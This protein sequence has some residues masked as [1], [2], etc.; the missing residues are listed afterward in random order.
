MYGGLKTKTCNVCNTE[1]SVNNHTRH[2]LSCNGT[3]TKKVRGV[4]FDPNWGYKDGSRA[5]WNKGK[6]SKP[7]NRSA[8]FI[9]KVGGYR[10]NAGRS[11]K[12]KVKDSLGND[13]TLQSTYELE[14]S[15]ILNL[16]S[17]RWIRPKALKYDN[18]NYF[19]DFYLLDYDVYLD[20]KN[21]YKAKQ[22]K[23]KIEKVIE[24][25][26]VKVF[27]LLKEQLNNEYILSVIR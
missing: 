15:E 26:G 7:D 17:I 25:N 16:L 24:Q 1:I 2:Q 5:A 22:D 20:P 18:K 8:E 11:K 19:A 13:T 4:D 27:V 21:N 6:R 14:C 10:P 23:E 12:F 3:I 9:G